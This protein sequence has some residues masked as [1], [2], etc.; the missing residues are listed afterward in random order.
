MISRIQFDT[1]IEVLEHNWSLA[2]IPITLSSQFSHVFSHRK[3]IQFLLENT[4][5]N[6]KENHQL[7]L[8]ISMQI[9]L[10]HLI[11]YTFL[12]GFR[13]NISHWPHFQTS[14]SKLK[15]RHIVEYFGW[16]LKCSE[17]WSNTVLSVWYIFSLNT[18][19][20]EKTE[21]KKVVKILC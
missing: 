5:R 13:C 16:K 17:I 3:N 19:M 10:A 21:Q 6:R 2:A 11:F 12:S 20:K 7:I 4:V 1:A 9:L 8:T 14:K 15:I 18:K